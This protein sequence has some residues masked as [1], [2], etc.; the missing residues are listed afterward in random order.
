MSDDTE[1]IVDRGI[2]YETCVE[3]TPRIA[4]I[5]ENNPGMFPGPGTNTYLVGTGAL[6]ILEPGAAS[7]EHF[8]AIVDA[9]AER[10]VAGIVPSHSHSDHWPLAPRLA[11]HF[12]APTLGFADH[13]GYHPQRKVADGETIEA[14]GVAL[15]AL[16]TPGH[17]S[18]HCCYLLDDGKMLFSGD[19]VMG[20]STS[21][22]VPPDGDLNAYLAS[23][24]RIL[25]MDIELMLSAHGT[26]I[27]DPAGR[28][29]EL[30]DHRLQRTAQALATLAHG[31]A[32][33]PA[34]V[35][36]IYRDVDEKLHGAAQMSL[37]AHL[38]ALL[39]SGQVVVARAAD[40][41]MAVVYR[42]A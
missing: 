14:E 40:D 41:P 34:M 25:A 18:D 27:E 3:L 33:I 10:P 29:R 8:R 24:E 26:V 22:I 39:A 35:E 6:F 4:R 20:W 23:L 16:H 36:T 13:L 42:L 21:V 38:L 1:K 11:E 28:T 5:T 17:C 15:T 9:V 31:P 30:Y 37:W 12:D 32:D 19:L 7:D 2:E